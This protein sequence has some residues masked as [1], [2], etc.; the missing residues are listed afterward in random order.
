ML[1]KDEMWTQTNLYATNSLETTEL[2]E[3]SRLKTWRPVIVN[4]IK[5]FFVL[6]I[7]MG[8]T[9]KTDVDAYW[10]TDEDIQPP[11]F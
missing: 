6:F 9:R 8:L 3:K 11:F 10:S 7:S 5:T 4:E 1:F 2:K